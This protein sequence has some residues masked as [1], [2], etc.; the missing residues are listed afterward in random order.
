MIEAI[1]GEGQELV[2]VQ[3]PVTLIERSTTAALAA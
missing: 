3:C 2:R 1:I